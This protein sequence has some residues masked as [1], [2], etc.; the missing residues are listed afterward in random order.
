MEDS[1]NHARI[2]KHDVLVIRVK[3]R[4]WLVL[5]DI[6]RQILDAAKNKNRDEFVSS[7]YS[8][9][10]TAFSIPLEELQECYWADVAHAYMKFFSF[11]APNSNLPL[12]KP[13]KIKP[14]YEEDVC[15]YPGRSWFIW[16]NIFSRSYGWNLEYIAELD[17]SD[18]IALYQEILIDEQMDKEWQW[19]LSENSYS[20]DSTTK[21]SKFNPLPKPD[22]MQSVRTGAPPDS[23]K[24]RIRKDELPVG[25]VMRWEDD[26]H[27]QPQ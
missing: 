17:V 27:T 6:H 10:S 25:L 26:R 3:L 1:T 4:A 21:K 7:V 14:K 19:L 22:W 2:G 18:A 8:Y 11:N 12:I 20:Y 15:E 16:A 23:Q 9:V 5:E 24:V 13:R